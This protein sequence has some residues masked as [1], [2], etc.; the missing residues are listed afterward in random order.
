VG[1]VTRTMEISVRSVRFQAK[2]SWAVALV[3][4]LWS[5]SV[6]AQSASDP[7]P[8]TLTVTGGGV[9]S[10]VVNA[11]AATPFSVRVTDP[12]GAPLAGVSVDFEPN[13]CVTNEALP[14]PPPS[15]YGH[16][17]GDAEAVSLRTDADG[18]ATTV[19]YI[20]GSVIGSYDVM[21]SIE[22]Q[23]V[24]GVYYT[25]KPSDGWFAFFKVVQ[26]NQVDIQP[27]EGLW[28][29]NQSGSGLTVDTQGGTLSVGVYA[30]DSTGKSAWYLAAGTYDA[31]TGIFSGAASTFAGGQCLGC[32]Y[33]DPTASPAGEFSITFSDAEHGT[34]MFPGG[35]YPIQHFVYGYGFKRDYLM[36]EWVLSLLEPPENGMAQ[37]RSQWIIF[38]TPIGPYSIVGHDEAGTEQALATYDL[39]SDTFTITVQG[40]SSGAGVQEEVPVVYTL[41]GDDRRLSGTG[42]TASDAPSNGPYPA[43]A[44][45][46]S[47]STGTPPSTSSGGN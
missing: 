34:F 7:I 18:I 8:V 17:A 11:P 37:G 10:I 14:C 25:H 45:R 31:S 24:N 21:A 38:D 39:F 40:I 15:L 35:S 44:A 27:A 26:V 22:T 2:R 12:S 32:A 41:Q 9:Q 47:F 46:L 5:S 28:W 3:A 43:F 6:F 16:F 13:G 30:Y 42:V 29:N 19:E 1:E 20:A 33:S 36:G 4:C 23:D